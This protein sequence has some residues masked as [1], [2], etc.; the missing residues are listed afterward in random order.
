MK[1]TNIRILRHQ[2]G[3]TI[4]EISKLLNMTPETYH[5]L[6]TEPLYETSINLY[7]KL[8][9]FHG[10]GLDYLLGIETKPTFDK[11]VVGY[12]IIKQLDKLENLDFDKDEDKKSKIQRPK[13]TILHEIIKPEDL[14][15]KDYPFNI[16]NKL[17]GK[18]VTKLNSKIVPTV[19]NDLE[20]LFSEYLTDRE[21]FVIKARY[22]RN[23][24]PKDIA[25]IVNVT[26]ERIRQIEAKALR[27]LKSNFIANR[28]LYNIDDD[29]KSK[30]RILEELRNQIQECD[31]EMGTRYP[32][33][34]KEISPTD[35]SFSQHTKRLLIMNDL[36]SL[37]RLLKYVLSGEIL[38]LNGIGE[39]VYFEI[40]SKLKELKYITY[41][42]TIRTPIKTSKTVKLIRRPNIIIN[43]GS[44][45]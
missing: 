31:I 41:D 35:F 42:E 15:I 12:H 40:L 14:T 39:R 7:I 3:Y 21:I 16:L 8:A 30:E 45:L 17:F 26:T 23:V 9:K 4:A 37:D 22:V 27:K 36:K 33:I 28:F 18:S 43:K 29:I 34:Y 2:A 24:K 6:E 25:E 5:K 44:G 10:V 19:V 38:N 11:A 32:R 1:G 13:T 20:L